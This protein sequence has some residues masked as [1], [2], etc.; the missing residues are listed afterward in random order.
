MGVG[1]TGH[2]SFIETLGPEKS[3]QEWPVEVGIEP[4]HLTLNPHCVLNTFLVYTPW[5]VYTAIHRY[6]CGRH[7][8]TGD[9][10]GFSPH[11]SLDCLSHLSVI[12]R[13]YNEQIIIL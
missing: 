2:F 4:A 8:W 12:V 1:P 9:F 11:L 13:F 7:L 10:G 6:V 5:A 3:A